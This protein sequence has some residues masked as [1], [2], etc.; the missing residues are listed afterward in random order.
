[1]GRFYA[2][3]VAV[4][5]ATGSFLFGYDTGVMTDVIASPNFLQYFKTTPTSATIGAINSTFSG[6]AMVGALQGGF[7]MDRFGRKVTI[8]LGALICLLGASLQAAAQNLPMILV[9]RILAG[10]A[11]GLMSMAVPVYQAEFAH[12]RCRGLIVGLT[13]QMIGVG[14]IV[15]T[16][17]GYASLH[18][19]DTS[20]FQWRFPLAFQVVPA[21]VLGIGMIF[22]PESPRHLIEKENYSEAI[23]VL[24]KLHFDGSNN[25]WIE[26]EFTGI[27]RAIESE[28]TLATPG[29][30]PM[31]T[32]P[33]WRTRMLLGL[34]VQV[35]TQMTGIN[36]IGYYQTIMY[37]G[38]GITGSRNTLVAGIY[39]CVGPLANLVFVIFILDRVGRRTPMLLGSIA[40]SLAL[41]CESALNSHN[42]DGQRTAHSIG[43]VVFL[44]IVSIAFSVSF[45]PCSWVYMAEVMPMQIRGKGN[46]FA[47]AMGNWAVG[48]LWNQVSPV[49][50]GQM[51]WRFYYVF[52]AWNLCVSLPVIYFFFPETKQKTLEE[53]DL[54][55]GRAQGPVLDEGPVSKQGISSMTRG[56]IVES[57]G[58]I[59]PQ[60]CL[61]L[62][63]YDDRGTA[64]T[65]RSGGAKKKTN[66]IVPRP[67]IKKKDNPADQHSRVIPYWFHGSRRGRCHLSLIAAFPH[68]A[69]LPGLLSD[70]VAGVDSGISPLFSPGMGQEHSL[71]ASHMAIVLGIGLGV[72]LLIIFSLLLTII[73]NRRDRQQSL[74]A[75]KNPD[76]R[77]ASLD[78]VSPTRTLEQWWT[79]TKGKMGLSEAVDG[80]FVCAVCLDQVNRSEEIREL[81][82]LHVFHR[83]CLERWFL[84]DHFNCPLCHRPYYTAETTPRND[85]VWVV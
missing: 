24:R 30:L 49:A 46:A 43:G 25:E 15:S 66:A 45:G 78:A 6:G 17:I 73:I 59:L 50:L 34:A 28:K 64:Q 29:W 62:D 72:V 41:I 58:S 81:Q 42:P 5:A 69:N 11:V 61:I 47:V 67:R 31:F 77:L 40:I 37:D 1:M 65:N 51:Q 18:A 83:E 80:Q 84:G 33:Q 68:F 60:L 39:N 4:L 35:F 23:C 36:V 7:T 20:Q 12:P 2:L 14:F 27:R 10:W 79:S 74:R 26:A 54:L 19:P 57:G 21:L 52:V 44:F 8:Q 75:R 63:M 85:Y 9:G 13:Q 48:T 3:A 56:H 70:P 38:L 55:F 71:K 82:C 53:I 22:L 16:W 32:V 76:E